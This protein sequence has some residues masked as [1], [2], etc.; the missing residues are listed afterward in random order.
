VSVGYILTDGTD[1]GRHLRG[2]TD[3]ILGFIGLARLGAM[4][5]VTR[6][7]KKG[8]IQ[9]GCCPILISRI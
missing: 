3:I 2:V 7:L 6:T 9:L 8:S 1:D 5:M 4:S